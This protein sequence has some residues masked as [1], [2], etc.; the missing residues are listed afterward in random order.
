MTIQSTFQ[1]ILNLKYNLFSCSCHPWVTRGSDP[2]N[3]INRMMVLHGSHLNSWTQQLYLLFPPWRP[4]SPVSTN[5]SMWHGAQDLL[6]PLW[7]PR[8][9]QVLKEV[10]TSSST[11]GHSPFVAKSV[12]CNMAVIRISPGSQPGAS[13][14]TSLGAGTSHDPNVHLYQPSSWMA[15]LS[16]LLMKW[17]WLVLKHKLQLLCLYFVILQLIDLTIGGFL[18]GVL[19]Q[20]SLLTAWFGSR[21]DHAGSPWASWSE[22]QDACGSAQ[23]DKWSHSNP[24][25]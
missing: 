5:V 6:G 22:A 23:K 7:V 9:E 15:P 3:S 17:P 20:L 18:G 25:S 19:E 10:W 11:E 16:L 2:W 1:I 24:F 8:T 21:F 13:G 12:D 14:V 4:A